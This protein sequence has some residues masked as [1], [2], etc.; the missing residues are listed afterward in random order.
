VALLNGEPLDDRPNSRGGRDPNGGKD[1]VARLGVD[2]RAT[3]SLRLAGGLSVLR[4]QGFHQGTDATKNT[5]QWRD[6]NENAI[7]DAGEI[8]SLPGAA[9]TPSTNFSRWGFGVDL[10]LRAHTVLGWSS[11]YGEV[12]LA[13]NLDRGLFV[14]DPVASGVDVRELAY[15]AALVQEVTP[16]GLAGFRFDT[17]DPNAD[18]FDKRQGKLIP[19]SQAIHTFSPLLGLVLPGHA[20]LIFQYDILRDLLAKDARGVPV[21]LKNDRFTLRLQVSL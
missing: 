4:G 10:R 1:I 5:V 20:R 17:Y 12:T 18:F 15:Y 6:A 19:T 11:L 16:Y 21:D 8:T 7:V 14:A 9:A 3:P 2:A 13:N